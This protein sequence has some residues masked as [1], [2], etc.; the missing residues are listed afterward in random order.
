MAASGADLAAEDK[1]V[2]GLATAAGKPAPVLPAAKTYT[3]VK[4]DVDRSKGVP[5][6]NQF[7]DLSFPA[8]QRGKLKNGIEVI[9]A[10]RHTIPVTHIQLQFDAGYAADQGR[11]L[12][13]AIEPGRSHAGEVVTV[14]IG[15]PRRFE[16][17]L[18][19]VRRGSH[20][21][22]LVKLG[23]K[24]ADIRSRCR[25]LRPNPSLRP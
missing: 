18:Q 13:T 24:P 4:S 6:V 21:P 14:P 12:G 10:E 19:V 1:A 15:L 9:L 7:P 8:V 25:R 2:K 11:K 16:P 17:H 3:T 20:L 23:A 22:L 5:D